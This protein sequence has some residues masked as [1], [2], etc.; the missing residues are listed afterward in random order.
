MHIL[1]H[2]VLPPCPP[3]NNPPSGPWTQIFRAYKLL[4]PL[5]RISNTPR[6][7]RPTSPQERIPV[8]FPNRATAPR[9][10]LASRDKTRFKSCL[11]QVRKLTAKNSAARLPEPISKNRIVRVVHKYICIHLY[12]LSS[13]LAP[14]EI[15]PPFVG[16][17]SK[18]PTVRVVH[19]YICIYL[20]TLY[21]LFAP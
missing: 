21:S 14:L 15:T 8:N 9:T 5:G 10:K 17:T 16:P 20:C 11:C 2:S 12:T 7:Q 18:N 4:P 1:I 6:S 19:K 13:L 3:G